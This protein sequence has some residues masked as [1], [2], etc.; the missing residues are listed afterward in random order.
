MRTQGGERERERGYV[1][2]KSQMRLMTS[3]YLEK[4]NVL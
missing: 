4:L 3:N 2:R 1:T